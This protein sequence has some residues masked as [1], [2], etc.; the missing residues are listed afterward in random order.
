MP[1]ESP[2]TSWRGQHVGSFPVMAERSL[3][4]TNLS[5]LSMETDTNVVLSERQLIRYVCPEKHISELPFSVEAHVPVGANC[6]DVLVLGLGTVDQSGFQTATAFPHCR[7]IRLDR[8][9]E[10][11]DVLLGAYVADELALAEHDV[12]VGLHAECTQIGA[13]K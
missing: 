11:A 3:R 7:D 12:G 2:R 10:L 1:S 8:E 4:G 5:A 6:L 13:S 9:R